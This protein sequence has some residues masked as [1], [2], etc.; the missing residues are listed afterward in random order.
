[1]ENPKPNDEAKSEAA[2]PAPTGS[3]YLVDCDQHGKEPLEYPTISE[4]LADNR[5]VKITKLEDGRFEVREM[6]EEWASANLTRE[7]LLAWVEELK[8]LAGMPNVRPRQHVR[9][10]KPQF[11]PLV[12]AGTK[13]QTVRPTPKR[14][15]KLGDLISLRCWLDK[16]YRSK[17]RVLRESI[18]KTVA[19][20]EITET[21]VRVGPFDENP[22][23]FA[24]ADGFR[25]FE[26]MKSW[27]NETHGL[28]FRGI[29]LKWPN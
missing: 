22:D 9:M 19:S 26:A 18:I 6:C 16:P 12:E 14:M 28:P 5:V 17:Q 11:A 20:C 2:L 27:F 25:D 15:P 1:M 10:F 29:L 24:R 7:Q 8:A 23:D 4:A 21:G 13:C 3:A